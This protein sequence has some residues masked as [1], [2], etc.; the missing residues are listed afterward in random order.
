MGLVRVKSMNMQT[1]THQTRRILEIQWEIYLR[2]GMMNINIWVSFN[3]YIYSFIQFPSVR[4]YYYVKIISVGNCIF[5]LL[6]I[7]YF[8]I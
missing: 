3:F 5:Q 8:D 2:I 1:T 4:F 6:N 7:A